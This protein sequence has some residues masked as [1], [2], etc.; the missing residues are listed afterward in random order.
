MSKSGDRWGLINKYEGVILCPNNMRTE[1][2]LHTANNNLSD[3]DVL[4]YNVN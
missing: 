4:V 3:S 2:E 1:T